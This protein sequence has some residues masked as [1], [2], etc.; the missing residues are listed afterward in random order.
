MK[1][2]HFTNSEYEQVREKIKENK[3]PL[4]DGI[5]PEVLKRREINDSI[6]NS[7]SNIL[8]N[9]EKHTQLGEIDMIPTPEKGDLS[10]TSNHRGISQSSIVTKVTNRV[11]LNQIQPRV[12]PYLRPTQNGFRP[13]RST[14][15]HILEYLRRLIEGVKERNLKATL[16]FIDFKKAF[17]S[18][19]RGKILRV[20]GVPKLIVSAIEL[21]YTSTNAKAIS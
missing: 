6:I 16:A 4:P 11:I 19:H 21:L 10:L 18:I 12:D 3:T 15:A 9:N 1:T 13:G 8:S 5:S 7:A 17:D 2:G 14:T 20:Y